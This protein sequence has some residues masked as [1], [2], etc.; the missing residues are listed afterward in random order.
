MGLRCG[1]LLLILKDSMAFVVTEDGNDENPQMFYSFTSS[2]VAL[3]HI[4]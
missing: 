3:F 2:K 4:Q 1:F